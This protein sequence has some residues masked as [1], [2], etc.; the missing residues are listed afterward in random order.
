MRKLYFSSLTFLA[1]LMQS[2][3]ANVVSIVSKPNIHLSH[4][5]KKI[6][7]ISNGAGVQSASTS[8][9]FE[10][11]LSY[12][13]LMDGNPQVQMASDSFAFECARLGFQV[14]SCRDNP[15]LLIEFSIGSIRFDPVAGWIAD[16]AIVKLIDS[17]SNQVVAQYQ[18]KSG[19]ITPTVEN[20]ISRLVSQIK[21][22]Y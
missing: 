4:Q 14:V 1:I 12:T 13:N 11:Q 22:I 19:F 21:K 2:C 7:I 20:I 5:Y 10:G 6:A 15:D 18:A 17:K 16:Q 8:S 9:L 3:T